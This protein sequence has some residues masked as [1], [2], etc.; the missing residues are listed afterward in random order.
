[1]EALLPKL[2]ASVPT[3]AHYLTLAQIRERIDALRQEPGFA[4]TTIGRSAEGRPIDMIQYHAGADRTVLLWGFEDPTEPIG[5]LGMFWLCDQLRQRNADLIGFRCNWAIIPTIN[6]DGVLRNEEWFLAPGDLR[7]FAGGSWEPPYDRILY[8]DEPGTYPE[9]MAWRAAVSALTPDVLFNMHDESHFPAPGYQ[10]FL[11]SAIEDSLMETH[12][13]FVRSTGMPLVD[14]PVQPPS[15]MRDPR[16]SVSFAF[17]AN[18]DC[19]VLQDESCGYALSTSALDHDWSASQQATVRDAIDHYLQLL[20]LI[21]DDDV[22]RIE[23]AKS[24]ARHA[25]NLR[26]E[27]GAK[28]LAVSCC[29]LPALRRQGYAREADALQEAFWQYIVSQAPPEATRPISLRDQVRVQLHLLFTV[30]ADRGY[31]LTSE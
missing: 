5:A 13:T 28:A 23:S 31:L 4:V 16:R 25:R 10:V 7:A 24:Q 8:W 1:V 14:D 19:M 26:P 21:K 15:R 29:A 27:D 11:S 6:P 3:Y 12:L 2:L 22:V 9:M 20:D 17:V 30:L 18:P